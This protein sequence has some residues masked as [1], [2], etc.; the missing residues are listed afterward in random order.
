MTGRLPCCRTASSEKSSRSSS[1]TSGYMVRLS[2]R[3]ASRLV[4]EVLSFR[5]LD[6]SKTKRWRFSSTNRWTLIE[7]RGQTLDFIH[8]DPTMVRKRAQFSCEDVRVD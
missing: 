2:A 5:A 1:G 7:K 4:P 3:P 6:P 8:H